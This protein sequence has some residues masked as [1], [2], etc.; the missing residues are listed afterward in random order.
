MDLR[1]PMRSAMNPHPIR[2]SPFERAKAIAYAV[3]AAAPAAARSV[4]APL[5]ISASRP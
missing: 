1:H 4:N 2:P 5:S 3:D